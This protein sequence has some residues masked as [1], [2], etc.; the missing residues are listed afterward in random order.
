M[1][2]KLSGNKNLMFI[3]FKHFFNT[4]GKTQTSNK[5]EKDTI[6]KLVIH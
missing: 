5:V 4:T 1:I 6:T 3:S 2:D